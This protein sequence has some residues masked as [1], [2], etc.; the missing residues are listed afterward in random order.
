MPGFHRKSD[1]AR[2][3]KTGT[4]TGAAGKRRPEKDFSR[5]FQNSSNVP[6]RFSLLLSREA[7]TTRPQ[8]KTLK[9]F[10]R[11]E[12]KTMNRTLR[13]TLAL[14]TFALL[15]LGN[16]ANA[17]SVVNTF[18]Y[19]GGYQT[20]TVPSGVKNIFVYLWGAGGSCGLSNGGGGAFI[21]GNIDVTP[22]ETLT[23]LVGGGG[24]PGLQGGGDGKGG[25]GGGGNL[26]SDVYS[27]GGGGRSAIL[28]NG[29]ELVDAAGGG[30]GGDFGIGGGA[31]GVLVGHDG[32][33]LYGSG[34]IGG[35]QSV[36]GAGGTTNSQGASGGYP[37]YMF[38]G[39]DGEINPMF[40]PYRGGGGGGGYYGGGGGGD[41]EA[42]FGG[43]GGGSSH[44]SGLTRVGMTEDGYFDLPGGRSNPKYLGD[45][46]IGRGGNYGNRRPD[47]YS[48]GNGE[49]VIGYGAVTVSGNIN[50]A[51]IQPN[52]GPVSV[53][54]TFGNSTATVPVPANGAFSVA[55]IDSPHS[56]GTLG[57]FPVGYS[58]TSVPIDLTCGNVSGVG[59]T[60]NPIATP[61]ASG[62]LSFT[63][64]S[65]SAGP[66]NITFT[67]RPSDGS[68][69][70]TQ[71]APV[72]SGGAFAVGG[73]PAKA[74]ILHI[75]PDHALAVNVPVD[76]S[77]GSV[78]NIGATFE[79]CDANNDNRSDVLDFGEL[80]NAYGAAANDGTGGYDPNV[81]FNQD[82]R[83]DVLD[84]GMLVNNYGT[85]GD[86]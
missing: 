28:L 73:F 31:G 10:T 40:S 74:G 57:I 45:L 25:F 26:A 82:G 67:F 34:G 13:N 35:T 80:V 47:D 78:T 30:G 58:A 75:K 84:F 76:L 1:A 21:C 79:N 61:A 5:S 33:G 77:Q 23:I 9:R 60:C 59:V 71:T 43:G 38:Q 17:Q 55:F 18:T 72:P 3:L 36:G 39:G 8:S 41:F 27:G 12:T 54:F 48:G 81:D 65:A 70:V 2:C 15:G 62:N 83:D 46:Y 56:A 16:A 51:G 24:T 4:A 86:P 19:T 6:L 29:V 20:F 7:K 50:F 69:P 11:K 85:Q 42:D 14:G 63:G 22:G 68:A 64:I 66:Q 44:T 53:T 52:A 37:G 32:G 49:V